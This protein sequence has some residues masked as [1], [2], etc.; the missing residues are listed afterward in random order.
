MAI[1]CVRSVAE[2]AANGSTASGA[3]GRYPS[4]Q[5]GRTAFY[6]LLQPISTRLLTRRRL[7]NGESESFGE[8]LWGSVET[9]PFAFGPQTLSCGM[10]K[11]RVRNPCPPNPGTRRFNEKAPT[12]LAP[13]LYVNYVVAE[14]HALYIWLPESDPLR[15][16]PLSAYSSQGHCYDKVSHLGHSDEFFGGKRSYVFKWA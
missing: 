13:G 4:E 5:C 14:S 12:A 16:L 11:R 9:G 8:N 2:H 10:E 15:N 1:G 3:G 7:L 6:C